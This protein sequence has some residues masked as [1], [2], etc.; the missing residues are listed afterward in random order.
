M[1]A[2]SLVLGSFL[3]VLFLIVGVVSGWVAREYMLNYQD[4]PKLHPEFFDDNGNV[5]PDEV[6]AISF[7]PDYFEDEEVD[8]DDND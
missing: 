6:L 2:V 7:H 1:L 5:I 4:R 8:D 3:I